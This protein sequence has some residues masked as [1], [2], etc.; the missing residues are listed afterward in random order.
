[1]KKT[2]EDYSRED[3]IR[4]IRERDRKPRFGLVWER[5]EIDHDRSV[6]SDFVALELDVEASCG[7][8][9][10]RNLIIEGDNFDALRYLRMTHAGRVNCIYIDPPYNTGNKDFIYNDHF[11]EKDD[12][13]RHSKWL[14]FLYRRLDLARELL[15]EDGVLLVSINDE[16]R[17]RLELLIDQVFPGTRIGS[18]VWRTKDTG[19]DAGKN[20]SQVH[21]HILIYGGPGFTF[22]GKPLNTAKYSKDDED[23]HGPYCLDPITKAH[24]FKERPNTYYPIQDPA[25]GY[26]YPCDPN[27][28]WRFA[29]EGRVKDNAKLRGETIEELLRQ[30][31]IYFPPCKAS[32]VMRWET[33][34]E[35]LAA[36]RSGKGPI[37]PKKKTPLLREDLPDLAFWIG[38]L[39]APGRPSR[40]SYLNKK[41]KLT[42]PISSWIA[43]IN[44]DTEE[45]DDFN[46]E[47]ME[48]L[49]SP[50]GGEGTDAL[51][52]IL[53]TKAF[54][55]PKPP[56]L[57]RSLLRQVTRPNDLVLDFFA[58]SG[59]TAQ[60]ILEL[61][62]E[63]GG[64]RRFILVSN[65]EAS[66]D[67][68]AKN[69]CHDV[70]AARVR[71]VAIG[72]ANKRGTGGEFAYL[73]ARRIPAEKVFSK[74]QHCQVWTAL[75]LIHVG[76]VGQFDAKGT[77]QIA[78]TSREAIIYIPKVTESVVDET[79][80]ALT[81]YGQVT[82]YSW[83]PA[84]LEH[85]I[86]D[87]RVSFAPIPHF[88]VNRFGTGARK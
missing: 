52:E 76:A 51:T 19:N 5:D 68:P 3:L 22:L 36:I 23:G 56:T 20:F 6:N 46:A 86:S 44:E 1:M 65:T 80:V 4:L 82:V 8:A 77:I 41:T 33:M 39:I 72:Y 18:M 49:R 45:L 27:S 13:Y 25:T 88:L 7:D 9:P 21:E 48:T 47:E 42:S 37:L 75:Q 84:L 26:W 2:Y 61:N 59:T 55:H 62:V 10:Y 74:V 57:L 16:N 83:Q 87:P 63:D 79:K 50:R 58:G 81:S 24:S 14:E 38:K 30:G 34:G 11:V 64:K 67:E 71:K 85:R 28:V 35:L 29:S 69:I 17:A 66:S 70:C 53:G 32:D 54:S 15:A 31:L 73:R 60:A 43:G 40:K 12:L 78:T